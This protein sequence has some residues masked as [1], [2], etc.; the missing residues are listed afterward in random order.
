MLSANAESPL[1]IECI[2]DDVDVR[3]MLNREQF[4]ELVAPVLA[5]VRAPVDRVRVSV[6]SACPCRAC[7]R[8][9]YV[10]FV[11]CFRHACVMRIQKG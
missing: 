10:M 9:V 1:N 6:P 11:P 5:R 2:M 8:H 3:S 7:L 4:E